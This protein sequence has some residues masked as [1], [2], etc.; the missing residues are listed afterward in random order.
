M[1]TDLLDLC[2]IAQPCASWGPDSCLGWLPGFDVGGTTLCTT[3]PQIINFHKSS[4]LM[5]VYANLSLSV[6]PPNGILLPLSLV[7]P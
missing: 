5:M 7:I 3:N 2:L 6:G 1:A 4:Q